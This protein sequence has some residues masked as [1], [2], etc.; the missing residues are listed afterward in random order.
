MNGPKATPEQQ[1]VSMKHTLEHVLE[2]AK[3]GNIAAAHNLLSQFLDNIDSPYPPHAA[4]CNT[5]HAKAK[6]P[7]HL[8]SSLGV[9]CLNCGH[10]S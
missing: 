4:V 7:A 6:V 9:A 5:C 10:P 8:G 1:L 2:L 3:G